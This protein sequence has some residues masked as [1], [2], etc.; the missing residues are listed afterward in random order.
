MLNL[1]ANDLRYMDV[2]DNDI[3]KIMTAVNV[4][5]KTIN[6]SEIRLSNDE[7]LKLQSTICGTLGSLSLILNLIYSK[8]SNNKNSN[9]I[10]IDD[11]L[12]SADAC[13][14]LK[15]Y[16]KAEEKNIETRL[17]TVYKTKQ[18]RRTIL[19]TTTVCTAL[20]FGFALRHSNYSFNTVSTFTNLMSKMK[21]WHM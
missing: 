14:M 2:D 11:Y 7:I 10:L 20:L 16:L 21:I 6:L 8:L 12:S 18:K 1:T 17:K 5:N 13:M 4:L 19:I 9:D 15:P 3:T